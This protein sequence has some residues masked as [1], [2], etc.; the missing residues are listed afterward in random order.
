MSSANTIQMSKVVQWD[1]DDFVETG[2]APV[3]TTKLP[4]V[5]EYNMEIPGIREWIR[6][7][8]ELKIAES[9]ANEWMDANGFQFYDENGNPY[10]YRPVCE[11]FSELL[12][13]FDYLYETIKNLDADKISIKIPEVKEEEE[14]YYEEEEEPMCITRKGRGPCPCCG[15]FIGWRGERDY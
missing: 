9:L 4:T 7:N 10:V 1:D 14:E 5:A 12:D 2:P 6:L 3:A 15:E 8:N 11:K 13:N